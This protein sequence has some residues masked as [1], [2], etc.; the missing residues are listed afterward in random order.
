MTQLSGQLM[1]RLADEDE[2]YEKQLVDEI[3]NRIKPPQPLTVED[4]HIR[5]MYIVSD[6]IN[7]QGGK[8]E[9]EDLNTLIDL[10]PDAPVMVGHKRDTLPVARNFHAVKVLEQNRIWIKSYF[11]WLRESDGAEDL[12]KNIDGGIYKECS[13]SFVFKRPECSVCGK[14][15]RQCSHLPFHEYDTQSDETQVAFFRYREIERVLE[16][17]LVYR[18]AI[19]DTHITDKLKSNAD[20][21]DVEFGSTTLIETALFTKIPNDDTV[22]NGRSGYYDARYKFINR[23]GIPDNLLSDAFLYPYQPG[24]MIRVSKQYRDIHIDTRHLLSVE[25]RQAI[26]ESFQQVDDESLVCDVLLY[27]V[28]GKTRLN[29]FGLMNCLIRPDLVHRIRFKVMDVL[30]VGGVSYRQLGLAA[31]LRELRNK[32]HLF[33]QSGMEIVR[34]SRVDKNGS[35]VK[36][37]EKHTHQYRYGSEIVMEMEDKTLL[38]VIFG[39]TRITPAIVNNLYTGK[40]GQVVGHIDTLDNN[41]LAN[42]IPVRNSD[43][44]DNQ[45]VVLVATSK[46]SRGKNRLTSIYDIVPGIERERVL[47]SGSNNDIEDSIRIWGAG[48]RLHLAFMKDGQQFEIKVHQFQEKLFTDGRCFIA[49]LAQHSDD[50]PEYP[51]GKQIPIASVSQMNGLYIIRL[52]QAESTPCGFEGFILRPVLLDGKERHLFY[53]INN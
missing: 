7:S 23:S 32:R 3:N 48:N 45:T 47:T 53:S 8:F 24:L 4:V 27:A 11:Y 25:M 20:P 1:A 50:D 13:I 10:M 35:L 44:I 42:T 34:P 38:R 18:G 49:D 6:T 21:S 33:A 41:N 52:K 39:N 46:N 30:L 12:R 43:L 14:D 31:R 5:A 36:I 51:D 19:A 37:L 17:S 28:R 9:E 29:G 2:V 26:I 40:N 15:I 22:S 16:T